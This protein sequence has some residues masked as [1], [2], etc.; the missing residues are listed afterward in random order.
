[1]ISVY[2]TSLNNLITKRLYMNKL[3][4]ISVFTTLCYLL[5]VSVFA[6]GKSAH[7]ICSNLHW[8]KNGA[9]YVNCMMDKGGRTPCIN[10]KFT[11]LDV[12][13][14]TKFKNAGFKKFSK[15]ARESKNT[16]KNLV[17]KF[18]NGRDY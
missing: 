14:Q 15:E 8:N 6:N 18:C 9:G 13:K 11:L 16:A 12:K 10:A 1:M 4:I 3:L 7:V 2:T 5:P 17:K